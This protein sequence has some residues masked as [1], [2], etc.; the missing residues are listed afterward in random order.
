[1][2]KKGLSAVGFYA[3]MLLIFIAAAY[4]FNSSVSREQL[5]YSDVVTA[6]ETKQVKSFT[7]EDTRLTYELLDGGKRIYKLYDVGLFFQ[8]TRDAIKE[9]RNEG[10][11]QRPDGSRDL[12]ARLEGQKRRFR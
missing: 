9:A 5:K 12:Y 11:P 3:V 2:K 1:M 10:T 4:F 6:F 8:D 7:I